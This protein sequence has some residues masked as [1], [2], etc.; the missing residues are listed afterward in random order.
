MNNDPL[1]ELVGKEPEAKKVLEKDVEDPVCDY[2]KTKY[3]MMAEKFTSPAKRSVPDRLF[4]TTKGFMFFIEFKAP[5]KEATEKQLDDHDIRRQHGV[6]VFVIDNVR[7]GKD[8]IDNMEWFSENIF[9]DFANRYQ[10]VNLC[11]FI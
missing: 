2:A 9:A 6:A 8:L 4:T 3:Q 7:A 5:G 10:G 11:F 1:L